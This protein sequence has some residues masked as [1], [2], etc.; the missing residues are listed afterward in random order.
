MNHGE[1]TGQAAVIRSPL[2]GWETAVSRS[3]STTGC[4]SNSDVSLQRPL[5]RVNVYGGWCSSDGF[6]RNIESFESI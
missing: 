4:W 6:W 1:I 2:S 5:L 3:R